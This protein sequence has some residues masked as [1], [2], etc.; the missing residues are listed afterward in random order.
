MEIL[1][2]AFVATLNAAAS[3]GELDP[4]DP[5]LI[6]P[7]NPV[8]GRW[9]SFF[10]ARRTGISA[11]LTFPLG[12]RY[13]RDFFDHL[14]GPRSGALHFDRETL[15]LRIHALLPDLLSYPAFESVAHFAGEGRERLRLYDLAALL[16][17]LYD[18]SMIYRPELLLAWEEG[19]GGARRRSMG[20]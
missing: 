3:A 7:Q 17:D 1:A 2:E 19:R 4:L 15:L 18:R 10:L 16:S 6:I 9:L 12:G 5:L 20:A 13:I 8:T 14:H 11:S